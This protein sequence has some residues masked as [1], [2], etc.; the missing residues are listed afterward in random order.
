[1]RQPPTPVCTLAEARAS[2]P[3]PRTLSRGGWG[4]FPRELISE[5]APTLGPL[6]V[7]V[8]VALASFTNGEAVAFPSLGTLARTLGCSRHLVRRAVDKLE[9]HGL[10]LKER[11]P[12]PGRARVRYV[13]T[14]PA[15]WRLPRNPDCKGAAQFLTQSATLEEAAS[16][17]DNSAPPIASLTQSLTQSSP[18]VSRSEGRPPESSQPKELSNLTQLCQA[19]PNGKIG[20]ENSGRKPEKPES[21]RAAQLYQPGKPEGKGDLGTASAGNA[22]IT[23]STNKIKEQEIKGGVAALLGRGSAPSSRGAEGAGEVANLVEELR[24]L[25]VRDP[26]DLIKTALRHGWTLGDLAEV[27]SCAAEYEIDSSLEELVG[28]PVAQWLGEI[29]PQGPAAAWAVLRKLIG[30]DLQE[31]PDVLTL[32]WFAQEP[33]P[34]RWWRWRLQKWIE[35]RQEADGDGLLE[36]LLEEPVDPPW[37]GGGNGD[38]KRDFKT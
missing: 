28:R 12:G 2:S 17:A 24:E 16:Q 38:Q 9:R 18:I 22:H 31:P 34:H 3:S 30:R 27:V 15:S 13:L 32:R 36:E 4:W 23:R 6:G 5:A 14:D 10:I 11:L 21:K 26:E 19:D 37:E 8:Y 7:A 1:M 20:H 35:A 29:I 25:D 33:L